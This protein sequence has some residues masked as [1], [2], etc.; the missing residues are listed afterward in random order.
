MKKAQKH[1]DK[2]QQ[3]RNKASEKA[4]TGAEK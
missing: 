1:E 4:N 3:Q 2:Q